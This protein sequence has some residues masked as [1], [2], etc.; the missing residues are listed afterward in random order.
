MATNKQYQAVVKHIIAA[1]EQGTTPWRKPWEAPRRGYNPN[2]HHNAISGKA[3]RGMNPWSL[4]AVAL[5][6]GYTSKLWLTLNQ[7]NKAGGKVKAGEKGTAVYFW[8]FDQGT[9]IVPDTKTGE[10]V[11]KKQSHVT[12]RMY[13]VFNLE[14]TENVKLPKRYTKIQEEEEEPCDVVELAQAIADGYVGNGGPS[15]AHDGYDRAY[16]R[17]SNDSIHLPERVQFEGADEYYST[18]FH[19]LGH[20]TGHAS[21]LD[22]HNNQLQHSFGSESYSKE[23]LVAEFTSALLCAQSGIDNTLDNSTAYIAGWLRQLKSD[24]SIAILAAGKAQA[25]A[26]HILKAPGVT[27]EAPAG[28]EVSDELDRG[29]SRM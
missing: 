6:G 2:I 14:Q 21:R 20:S 10:D 12:L 7:A 26:D 5:T 15:L 25:A 28:E 13:Y 17:P 22:R 9:K 23:E 16:Y 4:E 11:E 29:M 27:V 18:L 8:K 24:P 3:Y 1:L 19:E